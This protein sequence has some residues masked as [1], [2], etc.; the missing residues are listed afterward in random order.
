MTSPDHASG[1]ERIVE[2]V[3]TIGGDIIVN[4]QGDEPLIE[5][6]VID[7]VVKKLTD[8][9]E[10]VCSTAA[11]RCSD[12]SL[13]EDPNAVKVVLD[14]RGNAL[15][16]SRAA[17]PFARRPQ[18]ARYF[19]HIGIYM[20]SQDTLLA[21]CSLAPSPLELAESLEQLRALEN[22]IPILVRYETAK[23]TE[24]QRALTASGHG[25]VL[26]VVIGRQEITAHF[27]PQFFPSSC[28]SRLALF[29]GCLMKD[30][31]IVKEHTRGGQLGWRQL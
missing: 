17:I 2:A 4:V 1:T 24:G 7:T 3:N 15:Y 14:T 30:A 9:D 6:S 11:Y 27:F 16:F 22:G 23:Q 26:L 18:H 10:I 20:Y 21:L 12:K 13:Y 8:D 28:L 31:R 19:K 25:L 29:R 5:P